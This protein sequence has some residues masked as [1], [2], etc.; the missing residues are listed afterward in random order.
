MNNLKIQELQSED[1]SERCDAIEYLSQFIDD[2]EISKKI[3]ERFYDKDYIVRCEAYD[4]FCG[5]HSAKIVETLLNRL[6]TER[7]QCARMYIYA[8][9]NSIIRNF[10]ISDGMKKKIKT[11][12]M[13]ERSPK[14]LIACN[15]TMYLLS[16]DIKY[17][18]KILSYLNCEDY[19]IRCNVVNMLYDVIDDDNKKL[20]ADAYKKRLLNEPAGAVADSLK[21]ALEELI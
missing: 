17:I 15:A 2:E 12:Y 10:D 19:H 13:K 5:F 6:K 16:K 11:F 8:T 1:F 9:I 7:S 14:V 4:A 18:E 21:K 3:Q 20:I